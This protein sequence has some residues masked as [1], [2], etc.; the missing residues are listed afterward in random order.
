MKRS[1][2]VLG[3]AIAALVS[4]CTSLAPSGAPPARPVTPVVELT[5][6]DRAFLTQVAAKSMYEMEVSKLAARRA[7]DARV[8]AYARSMVEQH[9]QAN[10]GLIALMSAKGVAP[11]AALT[12]KNATK[13]HKLAALPPSAEFDKGYVR[14]V[15]IE[16]HTAAIAQLE[17]ARAE[18]R[19]RDVRAWIDRRLPTLRKQLSVAQNLAGNIA[20]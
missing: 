9:E 14:V 12:A 3:V 11:P 1:V 15:G 13:L 20:G 18:T 10:S 2:F 4:G 17:V 7:T 5:P 19:D 16:D 8:R 6:A